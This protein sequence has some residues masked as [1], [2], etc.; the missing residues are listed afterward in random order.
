MGN[1][2]DTY[3]LLHAHDFVCA[4]F[5]NYELVSLQSF[6]KGVVY[7]GK[8]PQSKNAGRIT[9]GFIG[10]ISR[11]HLWDRALSGEDIE[12]MAL[13]PSNDVGNVISWPEHLCNVNSP[14]TKVTPSAA[15]NT[16]L[17]NFI[18]PPPHLYRKCPFSLFYRL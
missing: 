11:L 4:F 17:S 8:N 1:L 13:N 10:K 7:I 14:I 18:C 3:R 12:K 16:G 5:M 9:T 2:Y 15:E 6:P